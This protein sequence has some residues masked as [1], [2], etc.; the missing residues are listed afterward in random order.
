M[1]IPIAQRCSLTDLTVTMSWACAAAASL[2]GITKPGR[3]PIGSPERAPRSPYFAAAEHAFRY[4]TPHDAPTRIA[5]CLI[6]QHGRL[7]LRELFA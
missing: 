6:G 2:C 1:N 5:R 3:G 7:R 4:N